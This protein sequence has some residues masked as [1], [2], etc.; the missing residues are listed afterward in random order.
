MGIEIPYQEEFQMQKILRLQ[1]LHEEGKKATEEDVK[2]IK[3]QIEKDFKDRGLHWG[4]SQQE[5]T[6]ALENNPDEPP[7]NIRL[8]K[9]IA[10][11]PIE[12]DNELIKISRVLGKSKTVLSQQLAKI[13]R[14]IGK[15]TAKGSLIEQIKIAFD[16]SVLA[17]QIIDKC[18]LHYNKNKIWIIWN[19]ELK[20]YEVTDEI[21]ILNIVKEIANVNIINSKERAEIVEAL[22]QEAR[23]RKPKDAPLSWVQYKNKI[24]DFKTGEEFEATPEFYITNPLP[25]NI[26]EKEDTPTIDKLFIEWVG[27]DYKKTLEQISSYCLS[28]DQFMQRLVALVGGGSNGKGTF[29]KFLI[30]LIGKENIAASELKEL[31]EN[32][33]ETATIYKK[34]LCIMGEISH[35]DLKNTNQIKKLSGEDDIRFCFKGKTPFTDNSITTLIAA[36]N[37]LPRTP[38]R[39]IGFY[40]KFL[41]VDFPNQFS[42][43][44]QGIIDSIP[45]EEFENFCRKTIKILKELYQTQKFHNEGSFEER[46]NRYEERSNPVMRF[47]EQKCDER[48]GTNTELRLFCNA[49]NEYAKKSHL[50]I[51]TVRQ[52]S[53]ILSEEGFEQ[54]KRHIEAVGGLTASK[55]VILNLYLK[56]G[57]NY[58]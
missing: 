19:E 2:N 12:Q 52:I 57:E 9:L 56:G 16:K 24:I 44:K 6:E 49:F 22:K 48:V 36:T 43:I 15:K 58:E 17:S 30:R 50:R 54:G 10:L 45:E 3:Q 42:E 33:F 47:I 21:D 27:E 8:K 39:T 23:K 31:A 38:D 25:H 28:S 13:K 4:S 41:I 1:K 34:L 20:K 7:I 14:D 5:F 46:M 18:P 11:N 55:Q 26:G 53:K 32:Q 37:S 40:R 35:D 51:M 29:I